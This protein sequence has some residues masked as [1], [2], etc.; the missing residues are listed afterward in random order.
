MLMR[1]KKWLSYLEDLKKRQA[2][3]SNLELDLE[4][5][6]IIYQSPEVN[7]RKWIVTCFEGEYNVFVEHGSGR[8]SDRQ[9]GG[10]FEWKNSALNFA[11]EM[12]LVCCGKVTRKNRRSMYHEYE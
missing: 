3:D 9:H 6:E 11:L 2:Q 5:G 10:S 4:Y 12:F 8:N 1:P 7:N